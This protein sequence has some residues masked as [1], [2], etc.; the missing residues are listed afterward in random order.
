MKLIAI[1]GNEA[2]ISERVGVNIYAFEILQGL[3]KLQ[4]IWKER[5]RFVIYLKEKPSL[6]LPKEVKGVWEYRVLSGHGLWVLTCL[7]PHLL[8]TQDKPSLLFSP[9]HYTVPVS[10]IPRVCAIMDLGYLKFSGQFKKIVFWQLKY[11]TAISI[12]VSKRIIAISKATKEDIVRHYPFASN[13]VEVTQLGFDSKRF[14]SKVSANDVRRIRN[15]YHIV[16]D[17]I[18]YLSTL[19][20]SKNV[21]GVLDAFGTISQKFP[22]VKLMIAGKK[23]WMYEKIFEKVKKMSLERKVV[24]TDYFPEE[25]KP[26]LLKGA[27]LLVTPS[28]W[29]G[30]GLVPLEAMAC[31]V[32]VVVSNSGSLPETVGE[33]GILVDPYNADSIAA[34]IARVLDMDEKRYNEVVSLGLAQARKFT[35]ERTAKET[36]GVL[37]A[38]AK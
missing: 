4:D 21:E 10:V 27:K 36:L 18:L 12:K 14:N 7:M 17:Y 31:G 13:K 34:G 11:W 29:E 20:P 24:F 3:Y 30:F 2:N 23:G 1:D 5:I 6:D 38:A 8:L 35:W 26:A 22:L 19:K 32:P 33:A 9:S 15:K 37:E 28:F 25:E 16:D